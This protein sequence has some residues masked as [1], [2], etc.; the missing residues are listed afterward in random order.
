MKP[1]NSRARAQFV[2]GLIPLFVLACGSQNSEREEARALLWRIADVD[3]RAPFDQ[4]AQQIEALRTMKLGSRELLGAREQCVHAH[5]GL[6]A[7]ERQQAD[8]RTRIGRA[9]DAGQR[10]P[11]ELVA[12]AAALA[13][14]AKGLRAA[15][16]AIP[17]CEDRVRE[18]ML[19]KGKR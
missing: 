14:A 8:A 17:Q 7:A 1:T 3:L 18:L 2:A 15:H 5:A 11:A 13:D 9:E 6:L 10:D 19:G 12:I 4:R 16:A